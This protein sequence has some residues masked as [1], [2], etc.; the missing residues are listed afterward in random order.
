MG[1][2][3][4]SQLAPYLPLA[5]AIELLE[6]H[7]EEKWSLQRMR[8]QGF[9]LYFFVPKEI[10]RHL[11]TRP[12]R[13]PG[14][15]WTEFPDVDHDQLWATN[16][17][18][19]HLFTSVIKNPED[20]MLWRVEPHISLQ[21]KDLRIKTKDL[22]DLMSRPVTAAKE[23]GLGSTSKWEDWARHY[24]QELYEREPNYS[25]NA[26]AQY[27]V[28]EMAKSSIKGPRGRVITN[29]NTVIRDALSGAKWWA[30]KKRER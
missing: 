20:S 8:E 19:D 24:A 13:P 10:A 6:T 9:R 29:V 30:H 18:E 25:L 15:Y 26:Y 12:D 16:S 14:G 7:T 5:E 21:R 28:E 22:L 23:A 3:I 11:S 27:A 2:S 17:L 1:E 4:Q